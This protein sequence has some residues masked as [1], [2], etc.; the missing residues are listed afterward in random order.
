MSKLS[1]RIRQSL[2]QPCQN[3]NLFMSNSPTVSPFLKDSTM[4]I[5]YTNAKTFADDVLLNNVGDKEL[6]LMDYVGTG[7][8]TKK[9]KDDMGKPKEPHREW[10]LNE[11][12][13]VV[14]EEDAWSR[15]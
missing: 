8:M 9:E 10:K 5:P 15:N 1:R 13:H 12:V 2:L 6:K 4:H 3:P 11:K 7:R 14:M